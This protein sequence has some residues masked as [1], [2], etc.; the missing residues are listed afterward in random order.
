MNTT[1]KKALF[2]L[3]LVLVLVGVL[4]GCA[5]IVNGNGPPPPVRYGTVNICSGSSDVYGEVF[6]EGRFKGYVE[7]NACIA[8]DDLR[9]GRTYRVEIDTGWPGPGGVFTKE[10]YFDRDGQFVTLR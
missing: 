9:L 2:S 7:P 4:S 6:L 8:V 5:I 1:I 3:P 10:F